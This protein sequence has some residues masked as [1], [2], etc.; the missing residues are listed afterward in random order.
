MTLSK[1]SLVVGLSIYLDFHTQ[2][3]AQSEKNKQSSEQ[4]VCG[5]KCLLMLEVRLGRLLQENMLI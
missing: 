1:C 4:Q 2:S 5:G 3:C